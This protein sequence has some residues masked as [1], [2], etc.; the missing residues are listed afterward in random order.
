MEES[1]KL[2]REIHSINLIVHNIRLVVRSMRSVAGG[3]CLSV[4]EH[5]HL[6]QKKD[7]SSLTQNGSKF[8]QDEILHSRTNH[9]HRSSNCECK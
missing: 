7:V 2:L 8:F 1:E 9:D 3:K 4:H 6:L 5:H